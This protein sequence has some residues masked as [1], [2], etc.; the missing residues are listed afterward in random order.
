MSWE[1][2]GQYDKRGGDTDGQVGDE[3]RVWG[4]R[5]ISFCNLTSESDPLW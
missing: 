2:Q 5:P 3:G 4:P 1:T